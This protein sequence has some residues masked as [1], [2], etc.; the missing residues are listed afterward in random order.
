ML[1][2]VLFFIV[3]STATFLFLWQ[4]PSTG[5]QRIPHLDKLVHFG[6]FFVLAFTFHRAFLLS[7]KFSLLILACYGLLIELAQAYSPGRSA[8]VYDWLADASG[9]V[10]YFILH[11]LIRKKSR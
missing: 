10:V 3:L 2:R 8:D 9:V 6:I 4:F 11:H 5:A 7:A 1:A